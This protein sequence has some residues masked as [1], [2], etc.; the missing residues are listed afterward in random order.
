MKVDDVHSHTFP[1]ICVH[2]RREEGKGGKEVKEVKGGR[3][4]GREVRKLN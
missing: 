3:K 4:E 1:S 2:R